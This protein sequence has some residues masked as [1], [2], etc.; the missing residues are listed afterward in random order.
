MNASFILAVDSIRWL[1][2]A[3]GAV[4]RESNAYE[5]QRD[6]AMVMLFSTSLILLIWLISRV[7]NRVVV[8]RAPSRPWRV[9]WSLLKYHGLG[10]SDRLLLCAI[11]RGRRIRQPALLLLSPSLFTRCAMQWLGESGLAPLWPGAKERLAQIAQRVFAEAG[12]G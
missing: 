6:L 4:W 2:Q 8:P 1:A 12:P 9:F 5:K 11:V 7:H 3:G 10:L